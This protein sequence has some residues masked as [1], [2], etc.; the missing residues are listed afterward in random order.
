M[1]ECDVKGCDRVPHAKGF[2]N[3][4]Y[5]QT[6]PKLRV[7]S[8]DHRVMIQSEWDGILKMEQVPDMALDYLVGSSGLWREHCARVKRHRA[9]RIS[10]VRNMTLINQC[11]YYRQAAFI[12]KGQS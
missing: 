10:Q 4:H 11:Y 8:G 5:R 9:Q 7:P 2:C 12:Q 1:K 3:K 6:A